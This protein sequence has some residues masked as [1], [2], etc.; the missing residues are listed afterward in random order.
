MSV[1][2]DGRLFQQ[3]HLLVI[4]TRN[5]ALVIVLC[6]DLLDRFASLVI[7]YLLYGLGD[8]LRRVE[9]DE[10]DDEGEGSREDEACAE[11]RFGDYDRACP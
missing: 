10:E 3:P 8:V 11:E 2:L 7:A 9:A 5:E 4:F 1:G 6:N